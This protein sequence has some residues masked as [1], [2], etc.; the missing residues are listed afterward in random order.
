M[1]RTDTQHALRA[2]TALAVADASLPIATLASR[3]HAPAPTLAKILH[4]LAVLGF[5]AGRT[6]RGGGYRLARPASELRLADLVH[7]FEGPAF[8]RSCLF[9]L[10]SCSRETPCP[11]HAAWSE[12]RDGL[13]EFLERNTVADIVRRSGDRAAR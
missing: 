3:A 4:R 13:L 8:G 7:A 11:L 6:G 9:G 1:L 12:L 2:L 10:P 5:V